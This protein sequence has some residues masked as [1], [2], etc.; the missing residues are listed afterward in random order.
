M[1]S[2]SNF[3]VKVRDFEH[4]IGTSCVYVVCTHPYCMCFRKDLYV[5]CVRV[6][7]VHS[8]VLYVFQKGSV[9]V[10][11]VCMLC[12]LT[13]T[14]CVSERIC[15]CGACV[16]VANTHPSCMCFRKDLYVLWVRVC[17]QHSPILYMFQE[18]SQG[19]HVTGKTGNLVLT[20]SRQGKHRE[21]CCNTGK[22]FET[23]GKYF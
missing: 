19:G 9:C 8:P 10:V 20:F 11:R 23:Q 15:M 12:A 5:W 17:C 2:T 22:I 1:C 6:C 13:C 4:V 21:F 16:Y 3:V 7:C 18:G 14:L